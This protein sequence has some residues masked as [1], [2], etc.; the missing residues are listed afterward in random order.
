MIEKYN[1]DHI[2][3]L[4]NSENAYTFAVSVKAF[5]KFQCLYLGLELYKKKQHQY[6]KRILNGEDVT[7]EFPKTYKITSESC[8]E[9][10]VP[11]TNEINTFL[12]KLR[13]TMNV[14]KAYSNLNYFFIMNSNKK[15]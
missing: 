1:E 8:G 4:R 15:E 7:Q 12:T 11:S 6:V 9:V 14:F 10:K 3:T 5:K 2:E 13:W